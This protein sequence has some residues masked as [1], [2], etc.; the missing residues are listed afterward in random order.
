[1]RIPAGS[2]LTLEIHYTTNGLATQDQSRIAFKLADGP[3]EHRVRSVMFTKIDFTVPAHDPHVRIENSWI[4]KHTSRIL[5][6]KPHTHMRGKHYRFSLKY[7]DGHT[8]SL[9]AVPRWDFDWQLE[10]RFAKPPKVPKGTEI[11]A[12]VLLDNSAHNPNN[13]DPTVDAKWGLQNWD[14]MIH[15]RMS[16]VELPEEDE[17]VAMEERDD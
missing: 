5:A 8:A 10:Y 12:T 16:I 9:L 6:V 1:M 11:I 2:Y 15:A 14:E 13:P 4:F 17:P 3:P 7:P